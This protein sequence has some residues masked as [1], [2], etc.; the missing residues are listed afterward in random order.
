M[1]DSGVAVV[2]DG[3][4]EARSRGSTVA[5]LR[6]GDC[7]TTIPVVVLESVAAPPP[8]LPHQEYVTKPEVVPGQMRSWQLP[9]GRYEVSLSAAAKTDSAVLAVFEANCALLTMDS[10]HYECIAR[11]RSAVVIKGAG[12]SP[13]SGLLRMRRLEDNRDEKAKPAMAGFWK[14]SSDRALRD[15]ATLAVRR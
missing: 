6:V 15:C 4:V 8:S 3:R 5:E 9:P 10:Q 2:R 13:F 11:R 14:S 12:Q 1:R 7:E